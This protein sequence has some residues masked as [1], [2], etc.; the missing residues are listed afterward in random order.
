M[1]IL[2]NQIHRLVILTIIMLFI[3]L[4]VF[5]YSEGGENGNTTFILTSEELSEI[6]PEGVSARLVV[7]GTKQSA[8]NSDDLPGLLFTEGPTWMDGVL[9]IS[10]L[11]FTQD[12]TGYGLVAMK[13]DGTYNYII[14]NKIRTNGTIPKGN[15][16]L[17]AC[18][19]FGH[20]IIEIS[21][22]GKIVKVLATHM[23]DGT[24][25]DGPNDL[26]IDARGGIYFTD[27]QYIPGME[28][29]QPGR[30]VNYVRPDGE[31]IRVIQPGEITFPNGVLLSPD[32]K[33]LYVNNSSENEQNRSFA[34]NY[35]VAYDVN[36]D[37]T[38]SNGRRFAQLLLPPKQI[39]AGMT[40]TNSD[41]MTIDERG[42]L[43]ATSNMGLQ[44]FNSE[45]RLIGILQV[46]VR[47]INCCFGGDDYTTIYMTC[48]NWIYSIDTNVKGLKYPIK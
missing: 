2:R 8:T 48:R 39:A 34:E 6:F 46:P 18:D 41:G 3:S 9:Y 42:N 17:V 36:E 23:S 32:G 19:M 20:R 33:T 11:C 12:C 1:K 31:V 43:Y 35:I 22:S 37:G 38:L 15:G 14:R 30:T 44:V 29:M 25:L 10:S 26:V 28:K 24:R 45:G 13:P 4:P 16:N 5:V 21:P 7:D 27:P 47:P 40:T